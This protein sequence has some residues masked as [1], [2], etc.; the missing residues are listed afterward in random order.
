MLENMFLYFPHFSLLQMVE[1]LMGVH[2]DAS[3]S[4]SQCQRNKKRR[5]EERAIFVKR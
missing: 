4:V 5:K 1:T 3:V 2:E